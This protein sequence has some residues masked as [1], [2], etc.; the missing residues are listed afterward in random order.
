MKKHCI[1]CGIELDKDEEFCHKCGHAVK[2]KRHFLSSPKMIAVLAVTILLAGCLG[3]LK[4]TGAFEEKG[5]QQDRSIAV[6]QANAFEMKDSA[7]EQEYII[8]VKFF[9]DKD[10]A[11]SCTETLKTKG[12]LRFGLATEEVNGQTGSM[13]YLRGYQN[14]AEAQKDLAAIRAMGYPE[15]EIIKN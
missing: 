3:V 1:N 11:V 7:L 4:I 6:S 10:A 13:V 5:N 15:A 8:P 12:Y 14:E 2:G 9:T